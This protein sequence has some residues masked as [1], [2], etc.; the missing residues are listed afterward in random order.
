MFPTK[1]HEIISTEHTVQNILIPDTCQRRYFLDQF[2]RA[3]LRDPVAFLQLILM[4]SDKQKHEPEHQKTERSRT[5]A[6]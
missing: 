1:Q 2:L 6:I 4:F 5:S 3:L